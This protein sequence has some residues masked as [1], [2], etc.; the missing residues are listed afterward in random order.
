MMISAGRI[1]L[2][3][4]SLKSTSGDVDRLSMIIKATKEI[5]PAARKRRYAL[6]LPSPGKAREF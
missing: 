6:L 4:N 5:I 1:P 2:L 3:N